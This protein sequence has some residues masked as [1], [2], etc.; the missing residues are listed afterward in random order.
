MPVRHL[1]DKTALLRGQK[2]FA[3]VSFEEYSGCR[4]LNARKAMSLPS[5]KYEQGLAS[6]QQEALTRSDYGPIG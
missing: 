5:C 3:P 2:G 1:V 6:S 4:D